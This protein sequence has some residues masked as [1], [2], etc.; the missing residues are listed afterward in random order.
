MSKKNQDKESQFDADAGHGFHIECI[1]NNVEDQI[2][3]ILD[4]AIKGVPTLVAK[5]VNTDEGVM[6]MVSLCSSGKSVAIQSLLA[7]GE[8][9]NHLCVAYPRSNEGTPVDLRITAIQK[10]NTGY[11][12]V[13][14][15]ETEEGYELSFFDCDFFAHQ[16]EYHIGG[17]YSFLLAAYAYKAEAVPKEEQTFEID[18]RE[19]EALKVLVSDNGNNILSFNISGLVALLQSD[20][21]YPDDAE[22]QSPIRSRV[23]SV[24]LAGN[25]LYRME[26]SIYH[27]LEDEDK[28]INIPL[29]AK[30]EFF[31]NKP[32]KNDPVRGY[33]WLIGRM[34]E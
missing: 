14:T 7:I 20:M 8:D 6:D 26:I 33:L 30:T 28:L 16:N 25:N 11:E 23:S 9:M 4:F 27:D 32:R 19:A 21:A 29:Y 22:F 34:S 17:K 10:Y 24:S 12:A 1:F 2:E 18:S 13:I 15:G 3:E 5:D 31:D